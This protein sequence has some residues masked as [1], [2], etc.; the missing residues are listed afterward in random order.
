[1]IQLVFAHACDVGLLVSASGS[2]TAIPFNRTDVGG[3]VAPM[4][5]NGA[6]AV[7][8]GH[9][10]LLAIAAACV[11]VCGVVPHLP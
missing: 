7:P 6:P 3:V 5:T 1:M 9:W 11:L 10:Q 8:V 2:A 4:V